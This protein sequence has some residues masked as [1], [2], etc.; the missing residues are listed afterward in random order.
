MPR[1][2]Q[3]LCI[4]MPA[5]D[6][7]L[8]IAGEL[9]NSKRWDCLCTYRWAPPAAPV[10]SHHLYRSRPLQSSSPRAAGTNHA[11]SQPQQSDRARSPPTRWHAPAIHRPAAPLVAPNSSFFHENNLH[12]LLKYLHFYTKSYPAPQPA[13]S[14]SARSDCGSYRRL[15][16]TKFILF[17]TTFIICN[18]K[19]VILNKHFNEHL[20]EHLPEQSSASAILYRNHHFNRRICISYWRVIE[21]SWFPIEES[22]FLYIKTH[23]NHHFC[24]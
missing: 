20:N 10:R 18:T 1:E 12:L 6:R 4:H 7:S 3:Q 17:N 5:I 23:K 13:R 24:I 11:C 9:R 15:R 19:S 8:L 16:S 22:S 2:I 14:Y 21:K